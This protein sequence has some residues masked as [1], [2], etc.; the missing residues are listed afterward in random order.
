MATVAACT[1]LSETPTAAITPNNYFRTEQEVLGGL[2]GAYAALR[3]LV[4]NYY[5]LSQVSS[6]ENVV[7]TRGSDWFDNGRWLEIYRQ[8][9]TATSNA[10][11]SGDGVSGAYDDL[12]RGVSRT[13]VLL[14]GLE[15]AP[16][17][18][19]A[20]LQAE[21]RALRAYYYY[22]LL[23]FF[24]G[25]PLATT[26]DV[27]ARARVSADS[28]FKFVEAELRTVRGQLPA[29]WPSAQY[30][31]I[32]KGGAAAIL[33]NMYLNARQLTGVM[34]AT[35]LTLGAA[36]WADASAWADSAIAG[37]YALAANYNAPFA[38]NNSSSTENIFVVRHLAAA[39]LGFNIIQ[40]SLH[41]NSTNGVGDDA[42]NGFSTIEENYNSYDPND[43]RRGV[44][45]TGPQRNIWTN[46]PINDR[47][48]NPLVFT[49]T[50][51]NVEAA[52]E[53]EGPR[54]YKWPGDPARV[55]P[56]SANDFA[57][58]RLAEMY[59]IKAE[60]QNEL[61]NSAAAIALL[62]SSIRTRAFAVATPIVAATQADARTAIWNEAKWELM[63]EAKGRQ[64]MIRQGTYTAAR[65]F[66]TA[67]PLFKYRFPIP[68]PQID[69]NSNLVQNAGY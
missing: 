69:V 38:V 52:T 53:G 21:V 30:G 2:A 55:G 45:L 8:G 26:P 35:G 47:A 33:A 68:Q 19:K 63:G 17:T 48:G 67:Q 18:N 28:L 43:R 13:N 23:D 40:R 34:T 57:F 4:W 10:T 1:D 29:S 50:I 32:T 16:V 9:W 27:E 41:Y 22:L 15:T 46:A 61:G 62:N 39:D 31:R 64:R 59:L 60:A 66:K 49:T 36:R 14:A 6:E 56:N 12:F 44:W 24:G 42:W 20:A 65:R 37:P 3:P 25:V 11:L 7:P 58:F 54:L 5:N 51:A